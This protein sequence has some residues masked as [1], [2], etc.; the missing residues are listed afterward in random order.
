M[1]LELL[2]EFLLILSLVP[3]ALSLEDL[4][5][6]N[7]ESHVTRRHCIT[8]RHWWS[9]WVVGGVGR[10]GEGRREVDVR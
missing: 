8:H 10:G 6:Q 9:L 2:H 3:L 5:G 7:G 4:V 1:Y